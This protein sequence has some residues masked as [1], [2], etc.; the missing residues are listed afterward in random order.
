VPEPLHD[1]PS[2]T[3]P[4][5]Q[6]RARHWTAAPGYAQAAGSLPSHAPPQALPSVT[7]A[8]RAPCG[9]P[10]TVL[11]VPTWPGTSHAWH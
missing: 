7:H 2:V 4:S 11:H 3:T 1:A 9:E 10:I 6:D 8:W 5:V